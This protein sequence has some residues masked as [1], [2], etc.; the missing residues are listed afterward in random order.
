MFSRCL[1]LFV[2]CFFTD[3]SDPFTPGTFDFDTG[4]CVQSLGHSR[5]QPLPSVA[6]RAEPVPING[7]PPQPK[8]ARPRLPIAPMPRLSSWARGTLL[9]PAGAQSA[10][11]DG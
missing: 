11:D 3:V 8:V 9:R 5:S 2:L 4:H 10:A 1:I 6:V 7:L